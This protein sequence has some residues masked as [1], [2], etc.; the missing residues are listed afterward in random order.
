M[1]NQFKIKISRF[2]DNVS[3]LFWN[4]NLNL[5]G[6]LISS[7][8]R[9]LICKEFF[10]K[11]KNYNNI[12]ELNN[13]VEYKLKKFKNKKR[14]INIGK[15]NKKILLLYRRKTKL[16]WFDFFK[17][18]AKSYRFLNIEKVSYINE[19]IDNKK[20]IQNF[21]NKFLEVVIS[22][23]P[24]LIVLDINYFPNK[25]TL[26]PS[27]LIFLK[28]FYSKKVI[29]FIGDFYKPEHFKIAKLWSKGI[30]V[31]F[32]GNEII[33]NKTFKD[34]K[35]KY[36]PFTS[37][38]SIFYP[39]TKSIDLFFSGIGNIYRFKYLF[40]IKKKF[41]IFNIKLFVHKSNKQPSLTY[42]K[43]VKNIRRSGSVINFTRRGEN[44]FHG[45]G[46]RFEAMASKTL[47]LNEHNTFK[48]ILIPYVHYIPFETAHEL[49]LAINFSKK[50][51]N[52]ISKIV[53]NSYNEFYDNYSFD[54]INTKLRKFNLLN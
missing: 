28:K 19:K 53:Q 16:M 42:N 38:S 47:I 18:K 8:G 46:N 27:I 3:F 25:N 43:Y 49:A 4:N 20:N 10:L 32:H 36:L 6:Y 44:Y 13:I 17:K 52:K 2:F 22:Y 15:K 34:K 41:E 45:G 50:Y 9:N 33:K 14:K 12:C 40:F 29:G 5:L 24:D 39:E 51:P 21:Q 1:L 48:K 7:Y 31:I 35:I 54:A 37:D 11:N 23:K 26:N 30:D